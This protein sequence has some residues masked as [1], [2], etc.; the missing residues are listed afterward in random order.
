MF[1]LGIFHLGLYFRKTDDKENLSFA[2]LAITI[3]IYDLFCYGLYNSHSLEEGIFWQKLQLLNADIISITLGW[4]VLH[5]SKKMPRKLF[6]FIIVLY[7]TFLLLG[8]FIQSELTLS[9]NK[10]AIKYIKIFNYNITYYEGTPGLIFI[11]QGIS[12]IINY[13]YFLL[14]L[15]MSLRKAKKIYNSCNHFI[16]NFFLFYC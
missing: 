1:F 4:F 11:I 7:M 10:P 15:I 9:L 6:I 3:G 14:I 8:I 16:N 12:Q 2:I 13:I 5:L